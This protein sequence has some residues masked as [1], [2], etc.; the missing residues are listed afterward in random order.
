M[1]KVAASW[2]SAA[3]AERPGRVRRIDLDR[4]GIPHARALRGPPAGLAYSF[5]TRLGAL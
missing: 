3:R 4:L 5:Q 2:S 1:M